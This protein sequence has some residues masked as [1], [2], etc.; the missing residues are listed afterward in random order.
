MKEYEYDIAFSFLHQDEELALTL[1]DLLK[2][3]Q[4]CFIYTESQKKLAGTDGEETFNRVFSIESRIVVIL[5]RNEWG[6]S[7]WTRIE[8][9]AIRN[10]GFEEGYDFTILIPLENNV[11]PP[12]WLPKNRLWIGLKRWG[13]ESAASVIEARAQEMGSSI[14]SSNLADKISIFENDVLK[15]EKTKRLLESQEGRTLA[16]TEFQ[17][18]IS[19]FRKLTDEILSKTENWNLIVRE[20]SQSGIDILSYGYQLSI[21]FYPN[22]FTPYLFIALFKGYFNANG[23]ADPFNPVQKIS[24]KRY[25]V[26]INKFDQKGWSNREGKQNFQ[27]S[28]KLSE[29]W[30]DELT[31]YAMKSRM[32]K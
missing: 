5:F 8:E 22:Q 26:N 25:N 4:K 19:V 27:T 23:Q 28:Y 11:E 16:S 24:D 12:K 17:E 29:Y 6:T 9:T 30:I 7:K 14:K 3:R 32:K 18:I 21:Q 1:Y 31:K 13:I 10:R 20:N 2:E 15:E